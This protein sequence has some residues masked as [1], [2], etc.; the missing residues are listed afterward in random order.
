[1]PRVVD[2][3]GL[4]VAVGAGF[5]P[6]EFNRLLSGWHLDYEYLVAAAALKLP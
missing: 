3:A 1:M 4:D 5:L 2:A 6:C